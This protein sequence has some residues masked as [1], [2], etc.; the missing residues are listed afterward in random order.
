MK[1]PILRSAAGGPGYGPQVAGKGLRYQ[2][3]RAA[4]SFG[5]QRAIDN[6]GLRHPFVNVLATVALAAFFTVLLSL[7]S[8]SWL[9]GLGGGIAIAVIATVAT[10]ANHRRRL[11][12]GTSAEY[13]PPDESVP[14]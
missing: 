4:Q 7:Q 10:R 6:W 1:V 5:P 13:G 2:I 12:N 8:H 9:L 11:A 14:N 3:D